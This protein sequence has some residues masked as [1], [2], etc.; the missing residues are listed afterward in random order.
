MTD[1][2]KMA[3]ATA[4]T[5]ALMNDAMGKKWYESKTVWVNIIAASALLAQLKWGFAI[6]SEMQALALTVV[7]VIL[8]KLTKDPIVF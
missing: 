2:I 1:S 5:D 6:D 4:A 8:R 7:N 3:V